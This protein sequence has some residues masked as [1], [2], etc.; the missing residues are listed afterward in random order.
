MRPASADRAGPARRR[1]EQ[2]MNPAET[3]SQARPKWWQWQPITA[4]EIVAYLVVMAIISGVISIFLNDLFGG[5]DAWGHFVSGAILGV[6]LN[7]LT[8]WIKRHKHHA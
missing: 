8:L 1:Q 2:R 4:P 5:E 7:G 3:A 6:L